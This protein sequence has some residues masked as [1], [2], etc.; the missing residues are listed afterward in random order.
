MNTQADGSLGD[1]DADKEIAIEVHVIEPHR[2]ATPKAI[3]PARAPLEFREKMMRIVA[4]AEDV[5]VIGSVQ[6]VCDG[7]WQINRPTLTRGGII[8]TQA[9]TSW[10]IFFG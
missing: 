5:Q 6:C 2:N 4:A 8:D 1:T 10:L 3:D 7:E 9:V